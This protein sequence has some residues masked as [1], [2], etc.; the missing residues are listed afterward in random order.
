MEVAEN[1]IVVITYSSGKMEWLPVNAHTLV[2]LHDNQHYMEHFDIVEHCM[3]NP[4]HS[5]TY[6]NMVH[7]TQWEDA[8]KQGKITQTAP[9]K[10][11]DTNSRE[12][13]MKLQEESDND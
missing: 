11:E 9:V 13:I 2:Y 7:G 3:V 8:V 1:S 5:V 10:G 12:A 4:E 6:V